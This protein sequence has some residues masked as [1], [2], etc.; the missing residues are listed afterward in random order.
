MSLRQGQAAAVGY[1]FVGQVVLT[2]QAEKSLFFFRQAVQAF[3][4]QLPYFGQHGLPVRVLLVA[5]R[6]A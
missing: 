5:A 6:Q 1:V 2:A 3:A 4:H